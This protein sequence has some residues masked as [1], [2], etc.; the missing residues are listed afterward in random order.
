MIGKQEK[1]MSVCER[2]LQG[3]QTAFDILSDDGLNKRDE[4]DLRSLMDK[5][6]AR[7]EKLFG[8]VPGGFV[9]GC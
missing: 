2:L 4:A 7:V 1:K 5:E 8:S 9:R 3:M 6:M